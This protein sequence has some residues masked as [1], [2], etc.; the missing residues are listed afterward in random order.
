[1]PRVPASTTTPA[2]PGKPGSSK[3]PA[4]K[5]VPATVLKQTLQKRIVYAE[6]PASVTTRVWMPPEPTPGQ[7]CL[8]VAIVGAP[9][10]GKSTLLNQLL[11]T[12][13]SA[14]SAKYNTTRDRVLGV[15]TDKTTN[16]QLVFTDTPGFVPETGDGNTRYSAT[17]VRAAKEAVPESDVVLLV[18]DAARRLEAEQ[19]GTLQG[20][21][22]LCADAGVVLYVVAN[23]IDLMRGPHLT[24]AIGILHA[25]AAGALNSSAGTASGIARL[26]ERPPSVDASVWLTPEQLLARGSAST[27]AASDAGPSD[28]PEGAAASSA[29][30]DE[31]GMDERDVARLSADAAKP[32]RPSDGRPGRRESLGLD[33]GRLDRRE[34]ERRVLETKLEL[35]RD[36][37]ETAAF[38]AGLVGPGGFD[39]PRLSR[40][41][42]AKDASTARTRA[43][44]GASGAAGWK[45]LA[46]DSDGDL[47]SDGEGERTGAGRV[48][49]AIAA[50][51]HDPSSDHALAVPPSAV[52]RVLPPVMPIAAELREGVDRLRSA[53]VSLAPRRGWEY[54]SRQVTDLSPLERLTE[55]VREQLFHHLH[56]EVPYRVRQE[57][58]SWRTND[59]GELVIDQDLVVPS[60][61]VRAMLT[62]RGGGPLKTITKAARSHMEDVVGRRVHLFLHVREAKGAA[63][64]T[65]VGADGQ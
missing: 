42:S 1:M 24:R 50:V 11:G 25:A 13:V 12:R 60:R 64:T 18:I 5:R 62:A 27:P 14:V 49:G 55:I 34:V 53:L 65:V 52:Y 45:A 59:A 43:S 23:K 16:T 28:G 32:G 9:N 33:L 7:R 17:L 48:S 37:F 6:A 36:A 31:Q 35:L 58:R 2:T 38:Q 4:L 51:E 15:Y 10:A 30:E 40:R 44:A 29:A 26:D 56:K 3:L 22:Q 41:S 21:A 61:N 19:L 57:N 46:A 20:L 47:S 54:S 39:E 8:R 63:G